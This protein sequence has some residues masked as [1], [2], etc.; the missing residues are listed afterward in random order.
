MV[1]FA[2]L[3]YSANVQSNKNEVF[4]YIALAVLF[5]PFIK[6]ALGRTIWN[7]V[8][9]IVGVGLLLSLALP[10]KVKKRI[11]DN[12]TN[13]NLIISDTVNQTETKSEMTSKNKWLHPTDDFGIL[14][15]GVE[16]ESKTYLR[17]KKDNN[18]Q[19]F[20]IL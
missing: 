16:F 3:A 6:I 13:E 7:I 1:S 2:Y 15:K 11:K 12:I 4:I 5:Q 20:K 14:E 18:S 17:D 10:K 8:D 19:D 9:V